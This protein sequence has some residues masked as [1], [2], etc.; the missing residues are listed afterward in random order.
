MG[1]DD[2]ADTIQRGFVH[3]DI[4]GTDRFS[5]GCGARVQVTGSTLFGTMADNLTPS[6][7]EN[8]TD[9]VE[10]SIWTGDLR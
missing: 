10:R 4:A 1:W 9:P 7:E 3:G 8:H 5:R 2:E 6:G